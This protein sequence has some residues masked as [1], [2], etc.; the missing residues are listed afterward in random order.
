MFFWHSANMVDAAVFVAQTHCPEFCDGTNE[1]VK[2]VC[3]FVNDCV[4][5][6]AAF[7]FF[8][9]SIYNFLA[10]DEFNDF[11]DAPICSFEGSF[12]HCLIYSCSLI[13]SMRDCKF[14]KSSP[15]GRQ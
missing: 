8:T 15:E 10:L 2:V 7:I 1:I 6:F 5:L 11:F 13:L 14:C 9:V 4:V 3:D 12:A